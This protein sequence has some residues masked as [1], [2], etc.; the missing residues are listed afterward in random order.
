MTASRPARRVREGGEARPTA[1]RVDGEDH[2]ASGGRAHAARPRP[3]T[4]HTRRAHSARWQQFENSR[5]IANNWQCAAVHRP[6]RG[7]TTRQSIEMRGRLITQVSRYRITQLEESLAPTPRAPARPSSYRAT[8]AHRSL[9]FSIGVAWH[10]RSI[11]GVGQSRRC[12]WVIGAGSPRRLPPPHAFHTR[13]LGCEPD[14][15]APSSGAPRDPWSCGPRAPA[16]RMNAFA[17]GAVAVMF[18]FPPS[19]SRGRARHRVYSPAFA[20]LAHIWHQF[21]ACA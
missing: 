7:P 2:N 10:S 16:G 14:R 15:A 19:G 18:F 5:T 12:V 6:P 1:E 8:P 21:F 9:F 13:L 17:A 3:Q 4:R 20:R 11:A